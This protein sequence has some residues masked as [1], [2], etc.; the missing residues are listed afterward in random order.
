MTIQEYKEN[1]KDNFKSSAW[2][3]LEKTVIELEKRGIEPDTING[4][5]KREE[6]KEK[7]IGDKKLSIETVY[8]SNGTEED[9]TVKLL[10]FEKITEYTMRRVAFAKV[11]KN[12]SERVINRR[13]DTILE[14]I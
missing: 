4:F 8:R 13:I 9:V 5:G 10:V 3:L 6:W 7:G 11:P 1:V 2:D 14:N 12:A